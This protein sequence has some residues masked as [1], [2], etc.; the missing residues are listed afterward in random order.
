MSGFE[1]A[2][3]VFALIGVGTTVVAIA[4]FVVFVVALAT[5]RLGGFP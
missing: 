3:I 5:G 4:V 1:F 2:V